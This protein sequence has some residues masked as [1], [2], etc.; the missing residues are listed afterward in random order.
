M[1]RRVRMLALGLLLLPAACITPPVHQG[2]VLD[3]AK[4][5]QIHEGDSRFE[6]ESVLGEPILRDSLHPH[7]A[8]YVEDFED[9][10]SGERIQRG[11]II[12][13]DNAFRVKEIRTYGFGQDKEE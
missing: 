8:N 1:M 11:V 6:V 5:Q 13:Y 9:P 2:N 4:I 3:V 10:D 7:R 12:E